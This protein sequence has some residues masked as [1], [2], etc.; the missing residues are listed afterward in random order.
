[1]SEMTSVTTITTSTVAS[2]FLGKDEAP[3]RT[4]VHEDL[5]TGRTVGPNSG[6]RDGHHADEESVLSALTRYEQTIVQHS[7]R[8]TG[9]DTHC[10]R[11]V[12]HLAHWYARTY[13]TA[14]TIAALRDDRHAWDMAH[15]YRAY[16]DRTHSPSNYRKKR[17]HI[18]VFMQWCI[19]SRRIAVD[20]FARVLSLPRNRHASHT[21][22]AVPAET[23][24]AHCRD[25]DHDVDHDDDMR[26][27]QGP[28]VET[29]QTRLKKHSTPRIR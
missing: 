7:A 10:M 27:G 29:G 2:A 14:L 11:A 24:R 23:R 20:P 6:P 18:Q 13:G 21:P 17:E 16:C 5:D 25:D 9:H 22:R 19:R 26:Q 1:M 3:S 4:G 15:R 8:W 12:A 28:S